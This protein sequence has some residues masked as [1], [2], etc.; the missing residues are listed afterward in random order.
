M[1]KLPIGLLVIVTS[2]VYAQQ[3]RPR[4]KRPIPTIAVTSPEGIP[5]V[6]LLS[7]D[8][9]PVQLREDLTL[10]SESMVAQ[11][12]RWKEE[13]KWNVPF[14]TDSL[15]AF[16][17][18]LGSIRNLYATKDSFLAV[19]EEQKKKI[20]SASPEAKVVILPDARATFTSLEP[21]RDSLRQLDLNDSI[22]ILQIAD[23]FVVPELLSVL[24][25]IIAQKL[26]LS[27]SLDLF[28]HQDVSFLDRFNVLSR[29]P[30]ASQIAKDLFKD[31]PGA[32]FKSIITIPHDDMVK[33]ATFSPDGTKVV[34]ASWDK[35]AK[36]VDANTG[37]VIAT[38]RHA[39]GVFSPGDVDNATF[40]PDG[41]KIVTASKDGT[42]KIVD[43]NT[44]SLLAAIRHD[45]VIFDA[46]FSPD[47]TRV[48][49]ASNDHTAQISNAT[50][51]DPITLVQHG[52]LSTPQH[53]LQMAPRLLLL[54]M[55]TLLK[56]LVQPM[57][58]LSFRQFNMATGLTLQYFLQMV[59]RLLLLLL[60]ALLK[61]L[62]QLQATL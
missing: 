55:T 39:G 8:G 25:S 15:E 20:L 60:I 17:N 44:G 57:V 30:Q 18:A 21:L 9:I 19:N 54:L 29:S 10:L 45:S 34:T 26:S 43:A 58:I 32:F 36:I 48:V 61:L 42:A 22:A 46:A 33:N 53:F 24:P 11:R 7:D 35:T 59:P 5:Y 52:P 51:G 4:S 3:P 13:R 50:N 31:N 49:T 62:T 56:F 40:S 14:A 6:T 47:S 37:R 12:E 41:T 2:V 38:I 1:K 23:Y 27:E 16:L 28:A